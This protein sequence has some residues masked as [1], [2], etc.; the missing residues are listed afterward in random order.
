GPG[1]CGDGGGALGATLLAAG[2]GDELAV[3]TAGLTLGA[4]GRPMLAALGV[5]RLADA[6]RFAQIG[7]EAAGPDI[8]HRWGRIGP[9]VGVPDVTGV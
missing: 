2:L 5:E 3:C 6:P 7:V 9:A 1:G 4:E 8:L